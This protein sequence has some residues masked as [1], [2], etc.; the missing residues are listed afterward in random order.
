MM[1]PLLK[2]ESITK[3]FGGLLVLKDV[4]FEVYRGEILGLIG[5]NG[6]GKTTLFNI[7]SGLFPPTSGKIIFEGRDITGLKQHHICKLGI[8]R[9][10]QLI[11]PFNNM[12]VLENVMSGALFG[13]DGTVSM[14]KA[15]ERALF[16]LDFVGLKKRDVPAKSLT[17]HEKKMLEIARALATNP[18]VLLIDEVMAGLNATEIEDTMKLIRKIRDELGVTVIWIEHVMRAVMSL[19]ERIIVLAYGVV[20]AEGKPEEVANDQAVIEAYL[21]GESIEQ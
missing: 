20:I 17:L 7:I 6:A 21:G 9:T 8:A 18:K 13:R 3:K 11:R 15:R 10:F 14:E 1:Q 5:P 16:V 2:G 4:N 19:A 12:S